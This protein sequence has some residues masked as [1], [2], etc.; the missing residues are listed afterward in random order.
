MK[1][2]LSIKP[3]YIDKIFDGEKMF[4]F[5]RVLPKHTEFKTVIIYATMPVGKIVGEFHVDRIISDKPSVLWELT[6]EYAGISKLLFNQYFAG[7]E[8]AHAIKI[9][10]ARRYKKPLDLNVFV[11]SGVAPQS[12]CY[13]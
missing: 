4:E 9:K 11:A 7:K 5:R 3:E 12:F 6:E 10:K 2:L 13:L 1:V 8:T